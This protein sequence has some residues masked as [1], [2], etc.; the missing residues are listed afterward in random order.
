M[1]DEQ[2][3][4]RIER[5]KAVASISGLHPNLKAHGA[6]ICPFCGRTG[7]G[8]V[9]ADQQFKCYSSKC[10]VRGDVIDV[11]RELNGIHGKGSL[12][13]ALDGLE[14]EYGLGGD[15]KAL[16]TERIKIYEAA[17]EIYQ[18][19][20][21]TKD[22]KEARDY[23]HSRGFDDL[24]IQMYGIGYAPPGGCLTSYDLKLIHLRNHNL[25]DRGKD[26]F[27]N[28]IIF[29][30]RNTSGRVV[31]MVGRYLGEVPKDSKGEDK[32]PRYKDSKA[33]P[34]I[35]STKSHLVFE[36]C[37]KYYGDTVILT[38]GYPDALTLRKHGYPVLGLLGVEG[39]TKQAHKFEKFKELLVV[40]DNDYFDTDHPNY[41]N[42]YKSWRRLIP[43][44]YELQLVLPKLNI[45]WKMVPE[46]G[47]TSTGVIYTCKD[48]NDWFQRSGGIS[49]SVLY[50]ANGLVETLIE[51]WGPDISRHQELLRLVHQ[52]GHKVKDLEKYVPD[53]WGP[54]E[55]ALN[56]L[57]G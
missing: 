20:L 10:E 42:E 35:G 14:K 7:K 46:G 5:I 39:L 31:H 26:Y 1:I 48:V 49:K 38:E 33:G 3:Q 47:R 12:F 4:E 36:D 43:Q 45:K 37:I 56:V 8:Y 17:L 50:T 55:Y 15:F 57:G 34:G 44:L 52:T 21:F 41:P 24:T 18:F 51:R 30:I 23:L 28:R 53:E 9:T 11:Y 2:T 32:W 25:H 13:Q 6:C 19:I 22:G 54:I 27:L 40:A 29:P 16:E